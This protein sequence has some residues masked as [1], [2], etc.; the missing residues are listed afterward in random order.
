V[1]RTLKDRTAVVG[2]GQT[3]FSKDSGRSELQ[4][5]SEAV[6]AALDDAGLAPADVDGLVT[7]TLDVN[8][9]LMLMRSVGIKEVTWTSRTPFGGGG[10]SAT[11][12]HAAAAVASGAADVVV[13]YR[14]FNERSG[15]RFGQPNPG[16]GTAGTNWY[17]PYGLDTPAKMYA[18]WFQRYM[19]EFGLTNADF[20]RYSVVARKHA[21]TNP[22]AWFYQRPITIDDHQN[23]RWIVE[24][25]LRLLDCCQESDGGVACVVTSTERAGDLRQPLVLV[26]GA[27]QGNLLDGNVTC[28]YYFPDLCRFPEAESAARHLWK[29][30]GLGPADIDVAMI[31]E[32][33]SPV[34]LYQLEAYGF[35]GYGEARDFIADGQIE[36]GGRLPVN[37]N[38]GLLGEAYIHGVNNILEGVRQLR[39]TAANQVPD[40][41]HVLCSA[42]RSAVILGRP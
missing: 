18:L 30:T 7:F 40:V 17:R 21:A 37:T 13:I 3:E 19:H 10:A 9:E 28:N 34:V 36:L 31:Y 6:R 14:A 32:N 12:E 15:H 23:S 1:T 2:I 29:A 8:D 16:G 26:N 20:G 22:N 35:C 33:F 11:V 39:G 42:G 25:I 5:A 41:E 24:P 4:L 27:T 38:G